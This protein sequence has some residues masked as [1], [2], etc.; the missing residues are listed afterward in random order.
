MNWV[1]Q[2]WAV[3]DLRL[4]SNRARRLQSR[5]IRQDSSRTEIASIARD[6]DFVVARILVSDVRAGLKSSEPA[7]PSPGLPEPDEALWRACE[8][9]GLDLTTGP[10][11][12]SPA[13]PGLSK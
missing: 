10:A 8:G 6:K 3:E 5:P 9:L 12:P 4:K 1:V 2:F 11:L 13:S 7:Q